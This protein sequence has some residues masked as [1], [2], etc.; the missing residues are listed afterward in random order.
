MGRAAEHR[1]QTKEWSLGVKR[2]QQAIICYLVEQM[3]M[4]IANRII[5]DTMGIMHGTLLEFCK[6]GK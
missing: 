1:N 3:K 2:P 6:H 4:A 5:R